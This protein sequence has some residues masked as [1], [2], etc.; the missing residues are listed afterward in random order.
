[1][2]VR[3]EQMENNSESKIPGAPGTSIEKKHSN[4]Y[5]YPGSRPFSDN[6]HDRKLFFGREEEIQYLYHSILA[7]NH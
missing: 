7:K 1:M 2:P 3:R 6:R 4:D 5:R